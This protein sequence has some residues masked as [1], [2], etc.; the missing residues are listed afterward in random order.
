MPDVMLATMDYPET[1]AHPAF[2][3]ILR[4]NFKSEPGAG[5][6]RREIHWQRRRD[7]RKLH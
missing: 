7:D 6:V 4:V 3:L 2:N 5:I 1:D